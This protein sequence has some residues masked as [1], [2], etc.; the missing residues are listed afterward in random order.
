MMSGNNSRKLLIGVLST[1]LLFA[2]TGVAYGQTINSDLVGHWAET[3][4]RNWNSQGLIK[5]YSDGSFK[6]NNTITRGEF[7]ALI[8]RSFQFSQTTDISFIDLKESNWEYTDVQKAVREDY[9][10][11]YEDNSIRSSKPLSRQEAAVIVSKLLKMT[12]DEQA[13]NVFNDASSIAFWSKGKVGAAVSK[14]IIV[15]YSDHTFKPKAYITRAEAVVM[16]DKAK[17][18][19]LETTPDNNGKVVPE[20]KPE[21]Q[22]PSSEASNNSQSKT[23]KEIEVIYTYESKSDSISE[24]KPET[25][26]D[27]TPK[28]DPIPEPEQKPEPKPEPK[29]DPKPDPK[30]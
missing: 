9:I 20:T 14:K 16:L 7:M 8:N 17:S 11:G 1:S 22:K 27:P 19:I 21:S 3:Q 2:S 28:P 4:L 29:P 30:P 6:P 10:Y 15:G 26:P 25:I 12:D 5:G 18:L 23:K 24:S 13:A